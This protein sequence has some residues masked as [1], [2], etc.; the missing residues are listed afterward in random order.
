MRE[1]RGQ[2]E[3]RFYRLRSLSEDQPQSFDNF[4]GSTFGLPCGGPVFHAPANTS[5]SQQP[6]R[7][8]SAQVL[9]GGRHR[10]AH[11]LGDSGYGLVWLPDQQR[12]YLQAFAVSQNTAGA[13]KRRLTRRR[14]EWHVYTLQSMTNW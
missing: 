8:Q 6:A 14:H 7:F 12:E 11:A 5:A 2:F 13:P 1:G 10:Q 4:V 9:A 3:N